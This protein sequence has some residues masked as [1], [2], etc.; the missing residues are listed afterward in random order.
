MT[1][2]ETLRAVD[3]R[4]AAISSKIDDLQAEL[5]GL[6][7]RRE[8]VDAEFVAEQTAKQLAEEAARAKVVAKE[9]REIKALAAAASAPAKKPRA[10]RKA[11]ETFSIARTGE[12][13]IELKGNNHCSLGGVA[14]RKLKFEVFCRM[15][16]EHGL[17]GQGFVIDNVDIQKRFDA[18]KVCD[19]S[20]ELLCRRMAEEI[21]GDL[22]KRASA[23][24]EIKVRV[25]GVPGQAFAEYLWQ[26]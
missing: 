13:T 7:V 17:D 26:K 18:I 22:G 20:C 5:V 10:P 6:Q 16:G 2:L 24:K 9:L 3:A 21:K 12:F 19:I 8:E 4:I 14:Q 11:K 15:Q 1:A 23:L 25:W